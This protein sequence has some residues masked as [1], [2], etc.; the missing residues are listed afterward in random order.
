MA[1]TSEDECVAATCQSFAKLA[2]TQRPATMASLKQWLRRRG[3]NKVH[4]Q[5]SASRFADGLLALSEASNTA[6]HNK[7]TAMAL[8][9]KEVSSP[10][11][12]KGNIADFDL[13]QRVSQRATAL[14]AQ[15]SKRS[16]EF[17]SMSTT[18]Q[19]QWLL[20]SAFVQVE[21]PLDALMDR[22]VAA[23][24]IAVQETGRISYDDFSI[25]KHLGKRKVEEPSG[26]L[27]KQLISC[28]SFSLRL[29]RGLF[30]R[31]ALQTLGPLGKAGQEMCARALSKV[32]ELQSASL[33]L[34]QPWVDPSAASSGSKG[35]GKGKAPA[36]LPEGGRQLR[37]TLQVLGDESAAEEMRKAITND[38]A[39]ILAQVGTVAKVPDFVL[40]GSEKGKFQMWR[41]PF[42]Q[43]LD[44][45]L[46]LEEEEKVLTIIALG[47][48]PADKVQKAVCFC[49]SVDPP[50]VWHVDQVLESKQVGFL[51]ARC[52]VVL[53]PQGS[54]MKV[55]PRPRTINA[56]DINAPDLVEAWRT[57]LDQR[58]RG[59]DRVLLELASLQGNHMETPGHLDTDIDLE[60]P[61]RLDLARSI[62]AAWRESQKINKATRE[63]DDS[64]SKRTG[65]APSVRNFTSDKARKS[66]YKW[67]RVERQQKDQYRQADATRNRVR[68]NQRG[69]KQAM[70]SQPGEDD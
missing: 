29:G 10:D 31:M 17:V 1:S 5:V 13:E 44:C 15:L 30:S 51:E 45:V 22:L 55:W 9:L 38:F 54:V 64:L 20:T 37:A 4:I 65:P 60:G 25:Q 49:A 56:I 41:S 34:E 63:V 28:A 67:Q 68:A 11:E 12:G 36:E 19:L 26:A 52:E 3:V 23:G 33:K 61:G 66:Y 14:V 43:R 70:A 16:E 18:A 24:V 35:K 46:E 42:E 47:A 6:V 57:N 40:P 2:P 21:M 27:T 8:R 62:S 7:L 48:I 59:F 53:V 32:P 58:M 69:Y 39:G 50:L